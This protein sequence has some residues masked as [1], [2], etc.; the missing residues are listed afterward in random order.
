[1]LMTIIMTKE[2]IVITENHPK[3][4][5][6]DNLLPS[7]RRT[8]RSRKPIKR[9]VFQVENTVSNKNNNDF[10][11]QQPIEFKHGDSLPT[12]T[13]NTMKEAIVEGNRY[14]AYWLEAIINEMKAMS[15]RNVFTYV[16]E[17][18]YLKDHNGKIP[19]AFKSKLAFRV[20]TTPL[21]V[22]ER[23]GIDKIIEVIKFKARLVACGYSQVLGVYY[24]RSKFPTACFRSIMILLHIAIVFGWVKAHFDIGNAYLEADIDKDIYMYLP[25]DWTFGKPTL[26][27][28]NKNLYGLK[29]AGLLWYLLM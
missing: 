21:N 7:L 13:L 27:K 17:K 19:N 28:L 6:D 12:T 9:L 14:K 24:D 18:Q 3:V 11:K 4:S 5:F 23:E 2:G 25:L 15:D 29:Q 26:V 10:P 8:T 20:T 16:D 22:L 1:M